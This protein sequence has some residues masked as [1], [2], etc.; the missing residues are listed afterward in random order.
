MILILLSASRGLEKAVR[1][2]LCSFLAAAVYMSPVHAQVQDPK[3]KTVTIQ[4]KD[5]TVTTIFRAVEKQTTFRFLYDKSLETFGKKLTVNYKNIAVAGLLQDIENRTGLQFRT[6]GQ[7]ISVATK[8]LLPAASQLAESKR[9][10]TGIVKDSTGQPMVGVTVAIKG[11][12]LGTGTDANGKFILSVDDDAVLVFSLIGF[13]KQEIPVLQREKIDVVLEEASSALE[14]VVVVGFGEQKKIS[15]VGAQATI[16][17]KELKQPVSNLTQSLG[18]RVAG[19]VSVQRS[20]ELGYNDANIYIRGISTFTQGFSAPLT[21]VDGVP[22]S[23]SN[24]DPEDIESFSV[25]K[26][27]SAT[28]VYGVRGANGVILITT[29][30]GKPGKPAYNLRYTEGI[31]QF[32]KLPS[33]ADGPTYMKLSN[34]ALTTRGSAPVY[35]DEAIQKTADGSDPYLYPNVDWFAELFRNNGKVRNANANISGGSE[36]SVYYIGLGY[37]DEL[38]MYKTDELT[39]YNSSIFLKR[40]NVT[41]N[42]TLKP[43]ATTTV[44]LGI[45]GYLSNVNLPTTGVSDIFT[46]AYFMTPVQIPT[47]Y[48]DGKVADIRSGSLSNPWAS[49]TQGGYANQWRSQVYSNLRLTQELPFITKGLSVTGMF[50]FDAYNYTSNRYTK[51]PDTWLA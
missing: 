11:T 31:T 48:P 2:I 32:T 24:V 34:E 51:I 46:D 19:M 39:K 18:G 7:N 25:L 41:S 49:L 42:I 1:V 23:I 44:K 28:A 47:R 36:K 6:S 12:R 38:G 21:L 50:S 13:R 33:F 27:A 20:G 3:T 4:L 5:A 30:S 14:E 26:D 45:Q 17:P 43:S 10:I 16:S 9:E 35:S 8:D 40:Y 15:L 29:K 22:R 37:Y